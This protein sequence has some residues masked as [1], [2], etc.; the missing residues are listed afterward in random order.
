MVLRYIREFRWDIIK[1][2]LW[3]T[4]HSFAGT[5][6]YTCKHSDKLVRKGSLVCS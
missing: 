4:L 6:H 5:E 1:I 3:S 2:L